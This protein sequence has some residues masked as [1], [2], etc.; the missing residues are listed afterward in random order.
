[1]HK[2]F[3][4]VYG[5]RQDE[6]QIDLSKDIGDIHHLWAKDVKAYGPWEKMPEPALSSRGKDVL[7]C[8]PQG[9][10]NTVVVEKELSSSMD[11]AWKLADKG[12]LGPWDAVIAGVQDFGRGQLRRPWASVPGNLHVSWVW[13]KHEDSGINNL[14]SLLAGYVISEG[15]SALGAEVSIKWPNDLMQDGKKVCGILVEEKGGI[16]VAGMGVNLAWA[17]SAAEMRSGAAM[18]AGVLE[19][20]GG[21]FGPLSLW[22]ELVVRSQICYEHLL[23]EYNNNK[24]V[25]KISERMAFINRKVLVRPDPDEAYEAV[26]V[27]ISSDG[28]LLLDVSGHME[29]LYSGGIF[30]I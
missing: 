28:G 26:V 17:P 23:Q 21:G 1:M 20:S 6:G 12:I 29:T 4:L 27:G 25:N 30:Q 14:A 16:I 19:L 7:H 9:F 15:L 18:P 22:H 13:P 5:S 24:I 11:K 8:R 2:G 3:Y 10:D